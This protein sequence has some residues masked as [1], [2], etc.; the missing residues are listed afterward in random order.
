MNLQPSSPESM[1]QESL[2]VP[3]GSGGERQ[4]VLPPSV[5]SRFI[6]LNHE[7]IHEAT[8]WRSGVMLAYCEGRGEGSEIF[9]IAHIKADPEDKKIF[10]SV[11]GRESTRRVFL[12]ILRDSFNTIHSSF[13]NPEDITE[14][15]PVPDHPDADPLEYK[16]LLGLEEMGETTVLI[17]KLKL[18]LDL[19]Q[20]LDGYESREMRQRRQ[21]QEGGIN[22]PVEVM[23]NPTI[24]MGEG[25]NFGGNCIETS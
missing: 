7:K 13:A 23:V 4:K 17:G 5:V 3:A 8:Y 11:S 24:Q 15:V 2:S 6:V 12:S 10:I 22:F 20:L 1:N 18:R 19:R 16:E 21:Y 9:N 25:D 14:W